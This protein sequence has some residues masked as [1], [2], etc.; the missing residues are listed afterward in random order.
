MSY[1]SGASFSSSSI[2]RI[3]A[4]PFPTSTSFRF[5]LPPVELDRSERVVDRDPDLIGVREQL[6]CSVV[7]VLRRQRHAFRARDELQIKLLAEMRAADVGVVVVK[8]RDRRD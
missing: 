8:D 4:M 7:R 3:P 6:V 2:A 1:I 5:I